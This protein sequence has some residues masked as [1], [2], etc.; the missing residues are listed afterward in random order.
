MKIEI[1]EN[2]RYIVLYITD[3]IKKLY[4]II[5]DEKNDIKVESSINVKDDIF[6]NFPMAS[7]PTIN[8]KDIKLKITGYKTANI[9]KTLGKKARSSLKSCILLAHRNIVTIKYLSNTDLLTSLTMNSQ[10][11]DKI[12]GQSDDSIYN[13]NFPKEDVDRFLL[14]IKSD[15][16][17]LFAD[18]YLIMKTKGRG[19]KLTYLVSFVE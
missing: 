17:L 5:E 15:I 11:T 8:D 19:L 12:S 2:T 4:Y 6:Y 18:K 3:N 14:H 7:V 1:D 9:K 16:E 13:I 10:K